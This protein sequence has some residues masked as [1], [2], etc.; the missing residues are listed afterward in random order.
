M[1]RIPTV[2]RHVTAV[3]ENEWAQLRRNKVVI[4]TTLGPPLLLVALSLMVLF[5]TTFLDFDVT[6]AQSGTPP[7]PVSATESLGLNNADTMRAALLTPFLVMFQLIPLIVPI[8]IASYSIIGEK[9]SRSLEALLATPVRTWELL[10]GKTFASALPGVLATW[11]TY[12]VFVFAARFMVSDDLFTRIIISPTWILAIVLLTPLF[13]L[14]AVELAIMISSRVSDAQSAQQLGS[15]LV[16]PLIGILVAQVTGAISVG[17][18]SVAGAV[19]FVGVLDVLL[20][21]VSI[22][23]FSRETILMRWR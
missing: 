1:M 20:L 2:N 18:G 21:F 5:L 7:L 4:F 14:L 9:Q 11:Y 16:L 10:L 13:A 23:L 22:R 17:V 3:M 19:V 15:L 12:L 8:T 6:L